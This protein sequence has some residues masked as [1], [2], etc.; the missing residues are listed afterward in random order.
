MAKIEIITRDLK[1]TQFLRDAKESME[2][3]GLS[4]YSDMF[5]SP[6]TIPLHSFLLYTSDTGV[7][8][9]IVG[10]TDGSL[11]NDKLV[12]T[13]EQY[14]ESH[15]HLYA[16]DFEQPG[17]RSFI[18]EEASDVVLSPKW[19]SMQAEAVKIRDKKLEYDS[20]GNNCH[21][22]TTNAAA[23][24]GYKLNEKDWCLVI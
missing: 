1:N 21:M 3:P 19:K 20:F 4:P 23:A 14:D 5:A 7:K 18:L 22:V 6:P 16:N 11:I 10:T 12:V 13:V 9:I 17:L 8:Y 24:G 15:K 2:K